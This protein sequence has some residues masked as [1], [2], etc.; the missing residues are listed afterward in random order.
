LS[1]SVT[2][3]PTM[4]FVLSRSTKLFDLGE[5]VGRKAQNKR[6]RRRYGDAEAQVGRISLAHPG[7]SLM[8]STQLANVLYETGRQLLAREIDGTAFR[9]IGIGISGLTEVD[10]E[11][12][13]D[14]IEP[15]IA[16][17]AAAERAMDR[18][19][20]RFGR[21]AVIRGKLYGRRKS[22]RDDAETK[23]GESK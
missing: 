17:K 5:Q 23:E 7:P 20:T 14:L 21:D 8:I 3:S 1:F 19:R 18:L 9:L 2:V 10:G 22:R 15:D 4:P 11:D 6:H 12:P 16:R 13:V